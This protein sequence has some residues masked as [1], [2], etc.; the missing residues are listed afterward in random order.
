[1]KVHAHYSGSMFDRS[2][3]VQRRDDLVLALGSIMRQTNADC[4]FVTGKSGIAMAFA[5]LTEYSVPIITVRKPDERSHGVMFEGPTDYEPKRYLILDDF[6]SSGTTVERVMAQ[7]HN[8][9][10]AVNKPECVGVIEWDRSA[11]YRDPYRT[12]DLY[13][14]WGK[15]SVNVGKISLPIFQTSRVE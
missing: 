9:C 1:M 11:G 12:F 4:L 8:Y 7:V 2:I 3:L 6:V 15:D 5:L 10:R 13:D 14:Q